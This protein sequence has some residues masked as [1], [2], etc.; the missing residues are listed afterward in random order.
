MD[1]DGPLTHGRDLHVYLNQ[2]GAKQPNRA[3]ALEL[4]R[5]VQMEVQVDDARHLVRP[6]TVPAGHYICTEGAG[7][8]GIHSGVL[9]T[10]L[11]RNGCYLTFV[12]PLAANYRMATEGLPVFTATGAAEP[13]QVIPGDDAPDTV[14][15]T[16]T[17]PALAVGVTLINNV[18]Y[19][20]CPFFLPRGRPCLIYNTADDLFFSS[21]LGI[22]DIP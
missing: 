9:I 16:G 20:G 14:V 15:Q 10:P 18:A 7:G 4:R 13:A 21:I 8:V 1:E 17:V 12:Y 11:G 6:L 22:Q 2:I 5:H 3:E 19:V